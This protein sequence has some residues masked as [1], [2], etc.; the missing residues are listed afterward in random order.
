MSC[1]GEGSSRDA[2][3]RSRSD[4]GDAEGAAERRP[5]RSG[6]EAALRVLFVCLGNICRSPT[7]EGMLR[8]R[9]R[10]CGREAE[11]EVDSAGWIA[12]HDGR[13]PWPDSVTAAARRGIPLDDLRAR[14]VQPRDFEQFDL[15]LAADAGNLVRL[16]A[17]CPPEHQHKLRR[18]LDL[19]PGRE[20][21]DVPDPYGGTTAEFDEVLDL[22]E[23]VVVALLARR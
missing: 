14:I 23:E 5:F 1:A 6:P 15:I 9:A 20:G 12:D 13:P 22:L 16:R 2:R 4:A 19:V 18:M 11:F 3:S 10:A 17:M 7:A 21:T 8:A